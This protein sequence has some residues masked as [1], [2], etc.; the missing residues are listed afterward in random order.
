[1][2]TGTGFHGRLQT[3]WYFLKRHGCQAHTVQEVPAVHRGEPSDVGDG[4]T[5]EERWLGHL[6]IDKERL[7]RASLEC[8]NH[9]IVDFRI[10]CGRNKAVTKIAAVDLRRIYLNF[11]KDQLGGIPWV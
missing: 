11:S 4:G 5:S 7:V 2:I 8:S 6:F 9:E 1:M 10:F 3:P